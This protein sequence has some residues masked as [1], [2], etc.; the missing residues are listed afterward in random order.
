MIAAYPLLS[1][2]EAAYRDGRHEEAARD[3][4]SHVRQ[5]PGEPRGLALLG[6][7]A[8]ATGALVQGEMFL[9]QALSRA[10]GNRE[11]L[12]DLAGCLNQQERPDEALALFRNLRLPSD[13]SVDVTI[14]LLLDKLGRHDEARPVLDRLV[15]D[16]GSRPN[17]WIAYG[18]HLRAVGQTE[19]AIAAYRRSVAIEPELGD[20]WWG[21]ASIKKRVLDDSDIA[22]MQGAASTAV[23]PRNLAPLHFALARAFHD[24]GEHAEAFQHYS[25]AN[26]FWAESLDY[27]PNQLAEE[28]AESE[29]LFTPEFFARTA[30]AGD[31]SDAPIFIVSLPRS[32]STLLEQMLD[33]HPQ[34]E[35]L[36]ELPYIPALLRSM[37]EGATR[38][39]IRSVPE[40]VARLAPADRTNLGREYLRRAALHRKSD[41]LRFVDKLPHN[42]SN[43][44]FIRQ[45]LPNARIIDIRRD[46]MTCCWSNFS[47][48]FSRAHASSFTLEGIGRAYADYVRFMADLDRSLPGY[49]H[50]LRYEHLV[51]DPEP[52]LRGIFEFLGLPWD[53]AVLRFHE[54]KRTVR[55]PS[56]EQVRRPLNREGMETWRPYAQWLGPLQKSLGTLAAE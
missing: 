23:D 56:A 29:R 50:H 15:D 37:M 5:H 36:G 44:V 16:F 3:V 21:L 6:S 24:K 18:H 14:T 53:D 17:V 30:G 40:A 54:S 38:A 48:S 28:V 55:T 1:R 51:E 41:S 46:A 39:G 32:G 33:V 26:R 20:A 43:S 11:I 25:E 49:V 4:M 31:P 34:I 27:N 10:P 45:I 52:Q 9:R 22:T 2:A 12:R 42:W 47:H 7:V 19:D 8:V 35:A 13:P